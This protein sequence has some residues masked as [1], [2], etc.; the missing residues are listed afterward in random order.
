MTIE[1]TEIK[2]S[3]FAEEL[4][5]LNAY[6]GRKSKYIDLKES[7]F[8]NIKIFHEVW[9]KI[10]CGLKNGILPLSKKVCVKT[11]SDDQQPNILDI[12]KQKKFNDFLCQIKEEQ[13]NID[14]VY[15]NR[16]LVMAHLTK[17]YRLYTI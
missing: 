13:K 4:D 11:D 12:S 5:K 16:F 17:Y 15:L 3:E 10:V 14:I 8:K 7:V 6:P 9:E 2:Q 1:E